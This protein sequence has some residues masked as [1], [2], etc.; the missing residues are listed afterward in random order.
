LLIIKKLTGFGAKLRAE[1][2]LNKGENLL[3]IKAL[4]V[5][6]R[7]AHYQKVDRIWGKSEG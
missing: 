4:A 6:P 3:S 7:F 2:P 1:S 5:P